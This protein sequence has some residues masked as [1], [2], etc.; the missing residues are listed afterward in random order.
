MGWVCIAAEATQEELH[1]LVDHGVVGHAAGEVFLL[2]FVGQV[3]VQQQMAGFEEVAVHG[4]LLDGVAAVQQ[5]A[6][7]A[8]N[9][10]DGRLARRSGQETRIVGE[11]AGLRIQLA[12]VD[13]VRA[14][15]ALV[16]RHIHAGAAVTERQGG[17]VVS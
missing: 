6:L 4:Q 8:I 14:N 16:Y 15:A 13:N 2:R 9:V 3:S 11:H 7:V 12:D 1:L 17:F 5:L 10:G